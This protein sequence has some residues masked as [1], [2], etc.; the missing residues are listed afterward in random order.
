MFIALLGLRKAGE[1]RKARTWTVVVTK[2]R[3]EQL[4]EA[5]VVPNRAAAEEVAAEDA[6][7]GRRNWSRNLS[8][9]LALY[10]KYEGMNVN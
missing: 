5:A 4:S 9:I 1:L 10:L 7:F 6:I 8:P 2:T 3:R